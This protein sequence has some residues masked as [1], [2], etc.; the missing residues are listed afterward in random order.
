MGACILFRVDILG[1]IQ[2]VNYR[3]CFDL[4][5]TNYSIEVRLFVRIICYI[6][7]LKSS[8]DDTVHVHRVILFFLFAQ[9][10]SCTHEG[11]QG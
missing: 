2:L 1:C 5:F 4:N 8:R 11:E 6:N 3:V 9:D 10:K 7:A